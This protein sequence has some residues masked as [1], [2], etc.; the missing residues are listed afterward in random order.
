MAHSQ[1]QVSNHD[2]SADLGR[3][4]DAIATVR[5]PEIPP[6]SIVEMGMI[7]RVDISDAG[8]AHVRFMPTFAGCPALLVIRE[9]I[10]AALRA[11]GFSDVCVES[12]F[13]PPWTSDRVT[14]EGRRKLKAFG[15][16]PPQKLDGGFVSLESLRKVA[17]PYCGSRETVMESPFGPT[18]C[19]AIHYCNSCRQSFEQFKPV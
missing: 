17:C 18:L 16:A 10:E 19:R 3:A 5:D 6:L 8:G 14:E 11:A 13:D 2:R 15:L 1:P 12:V 4:W 9:Q 7:D